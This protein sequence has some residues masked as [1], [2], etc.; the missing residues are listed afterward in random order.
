VGLVMGGLRAVYAGV[1]FLSA[2]LLFLVE[3][4]AAK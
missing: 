1:I 3:P 2:F 4:M